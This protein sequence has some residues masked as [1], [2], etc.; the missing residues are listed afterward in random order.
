MKCQKILNFSHSRHFRS[1]KSLIGLGY[2]KAPYGGG[3]KAVPYGP[4]SLR[5]GLTVG[6]KAFPPHVGVDGASRAQACEK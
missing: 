2:C 4:G 6:E 5:K 3:L 1:L